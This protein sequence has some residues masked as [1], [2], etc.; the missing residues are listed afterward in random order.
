MQ[1]PMGRRMTH[2]FIVK[3]DEECESM[4]Y[5]IHAGKN[6]RARKLTRLESRCASSLV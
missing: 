6:R 5:D 3:G 1:K 2:F 4:K